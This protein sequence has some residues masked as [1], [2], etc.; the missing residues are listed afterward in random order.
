[1]TEKIFYPQDELEN[2]IVK[3]KTLIERIR[4]FLSSQPSDSLH[5]RKS[6]LSIMSRRDFLRLGLTAAGAAAAA[7]LD[8]GGARAYQ[9]EDEGREREPSARSIDV[10]PSIMLHARWN[11]EQMLPGLIDSLRAE[12]YEG[13]TY[14]ELAAFSRGEGEL[15]EKPVVISIDDLS[16]ARGVPAYSMFMRM[17]ETCREKNFKCVFAINTNPTQDQDEERWNS[18]RE[19]VESGAGELATHTSEHTNLNGGFLTQADINA[20][21]VNSSK[22]IEERTGHKVTTL[23]LPFGNGYN[24]STG[25]VRTEIINACQEAGINIVVGIAGARGEKTIGEN[26][27]V[28][29]GRVPPG[30]QS[31]ESIDAAMWEV[32]HW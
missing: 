2:K 24:T 5:S 1:M 25:E 22:M 23:I 32:R 15:P 10:P 19:W 12:G 31:G 20:E 17:A 13:V 27:V 30:P 26:D 6:S 21:I 16:M 11:H 14:K 9:S 18:V 4:A 7:A 28:L 29:M 8:V 3:K